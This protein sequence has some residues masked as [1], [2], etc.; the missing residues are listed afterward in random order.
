VQLIDLLLKLEG[1]VG[2][3]GPFFG[4]LP[5]IAACTIGM[6]QSEDVERLPA[7]WS[8]PGGRRRR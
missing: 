8:L 4:L 5:Q 1:G 3:M 6:P 7:E 2:Q